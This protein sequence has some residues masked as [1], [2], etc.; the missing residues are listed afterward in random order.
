M[1]STRSFSLFKKIHHVFS[2]EKEQGYTDKS[3]K[4]GLSSVLL[5]I[6]IEDWF[7][8][9]FP[10]ELR[11]LFEYA[12]KKYQK[13][14]N[15][16]SFSNLEL[17][18][19][20]IQDYWDNEI[21]SSVLHD[22]L[23]KSIQYCKGFGP[24]RATLFNKLDIKTLY[25]LLHFFPKTW[26]DRSKIDSVNDSY[27][28]INQET[29]LIVTIRK[30][31][32]NKK[33]GFSITTVST[34]DST[35]FLSIVFINQ[36]YV[37]KTFHDKIGEKIFVTGRVQFKY[38]K[39][40]M[41]N[42]EYEFVQQSSTR[43]KN[44]VLPIYRLTDGLTQKT[45]RNLMKSTISE[46]IQNTHEF[47][48]SHMRIDFDLMHLAE[49][50]CN[51]HFPL[52]MENKEKARERI[53]FDEFL[54]NQY[55]LL[56]KKQKTKNKK[57][58]HLTIT[59]ELRNSFFSLLPFTLT[60][61][62]KRVISEFEDDF[63]HDYPMKRLLH[64]DV[65]SGKTI[66]AASLCYFT[67]K[68]NYQA[69][70][71]APTEILARQIYKVMSDL[72]KSEKSINVDLLISDLKAKEKRNVLENLEI[73]K[74]NIIVGTHAIL[75]E[76]VVFKNLATIIVDEQHRFGVEQRNL[77]ASKVEHSL[78]M[79]A[80]S[81]T[82]I[83]RTMAKTTY[84][85]LEVSIL[86]VIPNGERKVT[87]K[88]ITNS[89]KKELYSLLHQII[90]TKQKIYVV[91]PLIEESE[92]L[93][94]AN[95]TDKSVEIAQE[96]AE[97]KIFLLHG[98]MKSTEK[99]EIMDSFRS[100]DHSILVSTT[101]IEV[102]VDVPEASVIWIEN[103]ERFGLAQLHQLRGRVGRKSQQAYCFLVTNSANTP[104]L[105]V[106]ETTNSGFEVAEKDLELRGP[107]EIFGK[108]QSGFVFHSLIHLETDYH[109]IDKAK[110]AAKMI[111]NS[112]YQSIEIE[113]ELKFR[114][115][116]FFS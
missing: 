47:L 79:L 67:V 51:I 34:N 63:K 82:P 97:A 89:Q 40:Q 69:V 44:S 85:D 57:G 98:K 101:V 27:Q 68:N 91:C 93:D 110:K 95:S 64:G 33:R 80:M 46:Q 14:S 65:G 105:K 6:G 90:K 48:Q 75:Q 60:E 32:E 56:Q 26:S 23:S 94:I 3:I 19:G 37:A 4:T 61:C 78:H 13:N 66:V 25:D 107:G 111:L 17:A 72:F 112:T 86:N 12:V 1:K 38:G 55:R 114:E 71:M 62:Q 8:K 76:K 70:F 42:P 52:S 104:R 53:V 5:H 73:G 35:G 36:K 99:K 30:V 22:S 116:K 2:K 84:G 20:K 58:I 87:T 81:A 83:P 115:R 41:D 18:I 103:A 31:Q 109:L 74:T 54:F 96:F 106:L 92:K 28:N 39:F 49:A 43:L 29:N 102:G 9:E 45:C 77:L 113:K 108:V 50:L 21:P 16:E 88:I 100:T 24:R 59:P 15:E 10:T 7:V 11:E